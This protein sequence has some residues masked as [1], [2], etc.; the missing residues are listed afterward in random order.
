MAKTLV[1][2]IPSPSPDVSIFK[3]GG[4]LGYHENEVLER[5][6][7]ECSKRNISKLV[8]DFTDLG[9]LGG[10]CA[11][12]IRRAASEGDVFVCVAGASK[13]VQ[14]FLIKNGGDH[15]LFS[16]NIETAT[17][18][19]QNL[20]SNAPG[21]AKEAKSS[22]KT[23]KR[24]SAKTEAGNVGH[25]GGGAKPERGGG[26]V[27]DGADPQGG[28]A[29][30]DVILLGQDDSPE[31]VP[32][33]TRT[34]GVEMADREVAADAGARPVGDDLKRKLVQYRALFSLNSEFNRIAEKSSL[35][36]VFLLTA[37]AQ[38][39]VES[40]AF[41]LY[42]AGE[43]VPE[44]AKGIE[45]EELQS[46]R[47]TI[48]AGELDNWRESGSIRSLS[49]GPLKHG[50]RK[51]LESCGFHFIAPFIVHEN[52][53]GIIFLG[54]PIR[55]ELDRDTKDFLR[56]LINQAAIAYENTYRFE[57]E[58]ERTLGLV[59]TL[60]SLIEE[61]T[62][63]RGNTDLIVDY[64]YALAL[65]LHYP[66]EHIRDLMY[67]TVLRDIGMIKVSD[68][69]VRSPREL[70]KEEWEIIKRHPIDGMKMLRR[71]KFSEHALDVVRCHHERFNGEGYPDGMVGA[72]IPLGARIVSVVES[73]AAMRQD[74]PTRPALTREQALNTLRE[75]WGL[76][77]DPEVVEGLVEIVE[78][79]IRTGE[80]LRYQSNELF[81]I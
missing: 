55:R 67:G 25:P 49:K 17:D 3:I 36:N 23:K 22:R 43:F 53:R 5:F 29:G 31:S 19:L 72:Q 13:T 80:R 42:R 54:K 47:I 32:E 12:I 62:V 71:M 1:E 7:R 18:T 74:R 6:F 52:Y 26:S 48:E 34:E 37:I 4:T 21:H 16:P 38:V 46:I 40:A 76:R 59:Q 79:E 69:I 75:N 44:H 27:E 81:K 45:L 2:K 14:N 9:S 61:N 56:I 10:G 73:Y 30:D 35:I 11:K 58:S 65:K 68:L 78:D 77:Y 63:S 33:E 64:A 51:T 50:D 28:S 39:G 15:I 41:F 70:I 60:I 8:I 66:E 57:E 24:V 20:D